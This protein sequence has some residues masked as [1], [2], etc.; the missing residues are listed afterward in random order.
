MAWTQ[1][2]LDALKEAA[3]K[4]ISRVTFVD[5]QSVDWRSYSELQALMA[6]MQR[7]ITAAAGTRQ[8][9]RVVGTGKGV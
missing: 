5:G 9:Y 3:A 1:T 2:H 6:D 7:D 8:T 4:G